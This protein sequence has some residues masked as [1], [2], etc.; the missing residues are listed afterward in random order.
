[1]SIEILIIC[2]G[3]C[4]DCCSCVNFKLNRS[5]L[6]SK[7][8]FPACLVV[9]LQFIQKRKIN[10]V[11]LKRKFSEAYFTEMS[12][13]IAFVASCTSSKPSVSSLWVVKP[14]FVTGYTKK[15]QEV[16]SLGIVL[17]PHKGWLSEM[18]RGNK[19][20]ITI[21]DFFSEWPE[22]GPWYDK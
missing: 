6:Y 18:S 4:S 20:I 5:L 9:V 10:I 22:A 16:H 8:D 17:I 21:T 3:D 15:S 13:V 11:L 12:S 1:M 14:T 7:S 19:C 2:L